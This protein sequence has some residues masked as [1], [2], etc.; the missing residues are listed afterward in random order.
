MKKEFKQLIGFTLFNFV[1]KG[2]GFGLPLLVLFLFE[3]QGI[4]NQIEYI[5]S[6]ALIL[7]P[8]IDGGFRNYLFFGYKEADADRE[9]F[10][11]E[12]EAVF[13]RLFLNYL[14]LS[15]LLFIGFRFLGSAEQQIVIGLACVRVLFVLLTTYKS[16]LYRFKDQPSKVFYWT[17]SA[18]VIGMATLALV[19]MY[20]NRLQSVDFF[21]GQCLVLVFFVL[22]VFRKPLFANFK[23]SK[24][25]IIKSLNYAWPLM[26]N[27]MIVALI[28]NFGKIYAYH[29]LQE[30]EMFELTFLLRIGMI[31]QLAHISSAAFFS[32]R[33]YLA[34]TIEENRGA[35]LAYFAVLGTGV[36]ISLTAYAVL[37]SG[38]IDFVPLSIHINHITLLIY[39][40]VW[41]VSAYF[42][43]YLNKHNKNI[44]IPFISVFS[45]LLYSLTF[46]L[47]PINLFSIQL[48]MMV[49]AIGGLLM[50]ASIIFKF[51][52]L[53]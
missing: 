22:V 49:S 38:F 51:K 9:I 25:F 12:S 2:L 46:V 27:A 34:T 8:F 42:E 52:L 45:I 53:K 35:I 30:I 39:Y 15:I 5:M 33:L 29:E 40:L 10:V 11:I 36:I 47:V 43:L 17:L 18:N 6:F 3:D 21:M 19:Y 26:L 37:V 48:A 31:I 4:Y 20:E 24:A 44:Y 13:N 32:K 23:I 41:C 14:I 50:V 1:D 28:N 16:I 7:V